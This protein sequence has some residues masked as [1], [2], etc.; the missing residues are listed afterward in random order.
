MSLYILD[1]DIVSLA[2]RG[3]GQTVARIGRALATG[4]VILSVVTIREMMEGRLSQI[5]RAK[6]PQQIL[7]AYD[8]LKETADYLRPYSVVSFSLASLTRFDALLGMKLNVG[9]DDLRIAAIALEAGAVVVTRNLR[10]FQ[11][12]PGLSCED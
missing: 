12:V 5:K 9:K 10:D 8:G 4:E 3:H 2:A 11:G 1:S 7:A 6:K